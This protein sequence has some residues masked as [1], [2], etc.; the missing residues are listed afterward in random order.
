MSRTGGTASIRAR[1]KWSILQP[2]AS[3]MLVLS[4]SIIIEAYIGDTQSHPP[5]TTGAFA[6]NTFVPSNTPAT[7][8]DDPIFGST[9]RR[10][11]TDHRADQIY[12]RNMWWS[13][14]ATKYLHNNDVIDTLTGV[15]THR[16]FST[17][18]FSG[19]YGFDPVDS[20][21]FFTISGSTI[22]KITLGPA[23]TY[24]ESVYFTAPSQIKTLGGTINWMDAQGRYM[25]VRYGPEPSVH[26][27]DRLN[28]AAGPYANPVDGASTID[29]GGYVGLSPD[30]KFLVGYVGGR[31]GQ[32]NMGHGISWSINHTDRRVA[33]TGT[34]F[35]ELCGDHGSFLSASDGR[36]YMIVSN[37]HDAPEIWRV[38]ITNSA[39]GLPPS[40][41]KTLPNNQRLLTV[42]W[43][44]GV[45]FSTVARGRAR[46][47]AF[48]SINDSS[49]VF[50]GSVSS[51]QPY[52]SEIVA[53][54][55][56]TGELRRLA[57]HRSRSV[58]DN[59]FSNPRLST[60]WGGEL[61][62][63]AS[64]FNQ[65]NQWDIF[66]IPFWT[67]MGPRP[68]TSLRIVK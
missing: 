64:N 28:L 34:N 41:Q 42:Y 6:Y 26:L 17:G 32:F 30:G 33:A 46:D 39:G 53:L 19:D 21:L 61:V 31:A 5:P 54:N 57:H 12:A 38:D 45:H 10:V 9:V 52:K 56:I 59:Y 62:G 36:N 63:W 7:S 24:D 23:G 18:E 49:D 65:M 51:W 8:Y 68:P 22:L 2:V 20:T 29:Q 60:S 11:T 16:G 43:N 55:V 48:F 3:M 25:I 58:G 15:P 4:G 35:W 40:S 67:S 50:N 1:Q 27:Y 44:A 47:W 13:A 66:A 37:C 14:D